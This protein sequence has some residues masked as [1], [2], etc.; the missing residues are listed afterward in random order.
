M[1]HKV[2]KPVM[3]GSRVPTKRELLSIVMAILDPFG[4]LA[5][6]L[7]FSKLLIQET[8]RLKTDWV[9]PIPLEMHKK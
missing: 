9:S 2:P 4:I 8:W 3:E 7:T 1:F 6:F 5:D